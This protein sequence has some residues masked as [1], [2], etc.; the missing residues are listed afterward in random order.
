MRCIM[1]TKKG[2]IKMNS[3]PK[4]IIVSC[5]AKPGNPFKN[6]E[7]LSYMALAAQLGGAAAIR[8]DG[9][10]DITAIRAKVTIPIIGINKKEDATG[11][12]VITPD[13]ASAKEIAKSGADI[14]ALDATFQES[15]IRADVKETIQAIK[16]HLGLPVMADISNLEEA[17]R[18]VE[19][20]ADIVATTLNGYLPG[21][22]HAEDELYVPNLELLH[23]VISSTYIKCPVI[24]EGR[25]WR[26]ED[27]HTAFSMGVHALVIGKAITNPMA[28]TQYYVH[29]ME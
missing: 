2:K 11:R 27:V 7:L 22:L 24:G 6:P 21:Q 12:I 10:E 25:F 29:A 4:G 8:A 14:I 28:A 17:V 9:V 16:K 5:Q 19:Y 1:E 13:F 23:Q 20:G 3:I 26:A 18:A 15:N